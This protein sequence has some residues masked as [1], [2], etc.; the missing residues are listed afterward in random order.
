MLLVVAILLGLILLAMLD[1]NLA[2]LVVGYTLGGV[3]L[4]LLIAVSL[5]LMAGA[6]GLGWYLVGDDAQT[7]PRFALGGLF[8]FVA[9]YGIKETLG[10]WLI[11]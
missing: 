1:K 4:L 10:R 2:T 5:G 6:F 7:A 8:A 11:D 9:A 3:M